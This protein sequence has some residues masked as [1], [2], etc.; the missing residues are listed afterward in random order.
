MNL[1]GRRR[2]T[3]DLRQKFSLPLS[4]KNATSRPPWPY[5]K[6]SEN[7]LLNL[8]SWSGTSVI[9]FCRSDALLA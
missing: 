8:H 6:T 4:I 7:I 3:F 9:P 2:V 5:N 1:G